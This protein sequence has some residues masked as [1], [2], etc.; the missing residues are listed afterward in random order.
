MLLDSADGLVGGAPDVRVAIVE[1]DLQGVVSETV[2]TKL[3]CGVGAAE[4]DL[5]PGD[6]D[7]AVVVE[8]PLDADRFRWTAVAV[9]RPVEG[10]GSGPGR[11]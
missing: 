4:G 8:P 9:D 11:R 7:D 10:S 1:L 6:R 2:M 3:G 5:L